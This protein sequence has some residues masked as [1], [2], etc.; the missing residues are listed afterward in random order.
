MTRQ[1][2]STRFVTKAPS[3][4]CEE[5][6]CRMQA[7][8]PEARL[9]HLHK[10][11]LPDRRG[12]LQ[13]VHGVRASRPAQTLH[14]LRDGAA[15]HQHDFFAGLAQVGNLARPSRDRGGVEPR[16][17][18]GDQRAPDLDDETLR[19]FHTVFPDSRNLIAAKPSSWQ[20]SPV[21]AEMQKLGPRQRR[22]RAMRAAAALRS[23]AG[24]ISI[25]FSTSQRGLR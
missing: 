11:H 17:S 14:A 12:S 24:S 16:P 4:V 21:S 1:S 15:R 7:V 18:I 19:P 10:A 13:L 20:P 2:A 8:L 5:H 9:V 6:L 23:P 3:V 22:L 25:L